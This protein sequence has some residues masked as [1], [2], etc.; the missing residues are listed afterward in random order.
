[1]FHEPVFQRHYFGPYTHL[2]YL[3]NNRLR[4]ALSFCAQRKA[5]VQRYAGV[6]RQPTI[7]NAVLSK[8]L[9]FCVLEAFARY[10]KDHNLGITSTELEDLYNKATQNERVKKDA[11][12]NINTST[13]GARLTTLRRRPDYVPEFCECCGRT[14]DTSNGDMPEVLLYQ[15]ERRLSRSE[16]NTAEVL[17]LN[18]YY[19]T[20]DVEG[21]RAVFLQANAR[22][23]AK[24]DA[25]KRNKAAFK[26][27]R[28]G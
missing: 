21:D 28:H 6:E 7:D 25:Y 26:E 10:E 13:T 24:K 15:G 8:I 3:P 12:T 11:R 22:W 2:K 27:R 5:L 9:I 14:A 23:L 19:V 1:M 20:E 16:R 18:P 4:I 17:T